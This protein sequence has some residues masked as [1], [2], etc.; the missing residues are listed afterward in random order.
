ML[1]R[2]LLLRGGCPLPLCRCAWISR[3]DGPALAIDHAIGL[4]AIPLF[5]IFNI[6]LVWR[7][8]VAARRV[9]VVFRLILKL[10]IGLITTK[11]GVR[12]YSTGR[13][14]CTR[15]ED[16]GEEALTPY[17]HHRHNRTLLR[18]QICSA[19]RMWSDESSASTKPL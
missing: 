8:C 4:V 1:F 13:E 2:S 16:A 17:H 14:K 3:H 6:W 5:L 19:S 11:D 18:R 7:I 12:S 9:E 10:L 15:V